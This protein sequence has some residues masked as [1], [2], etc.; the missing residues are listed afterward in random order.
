[1]K[2]GVS[3]GCHQTLSLVG[4]VWGRDYTRS[5]IKM[6]PTSKPGLFPCRLLLEIGNEDPTVPTLVVSLLEV[7]RRTSPSLSPTKSASTNYPDQVSF[8]IPSQRF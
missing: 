1:M 7:L 4:G 3:A 2:P 8:E 6:S 5:A